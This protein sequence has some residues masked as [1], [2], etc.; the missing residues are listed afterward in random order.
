MDLAL[1]FLPES[2]VP[3]LAN[4][5][6]AFCQASHWAQ[7]GLSGLTQLGPALDSPVIVQRIIKGWNAIFKWSIFMFFARVQGLDKEDKRRAH[8]IKLI[9]SV[10]YTLC[11]RQGPLRD[12]ITSTPMSIEL[13]IKLWL[14]EDD[15][16]LG[17]QDPS[18]TALLLGRMIR[19]KEHLDRVL[20]A[21]N[22]KADAITKI[23]IARLKRVLDARPLNPTCLDA[24]LSAINALSI[25]H[26][27]PLRHAF[28]GANIIWHATSALGPISTDMATSHDPMFLDAM[29]TAF[30]IV[31]NHL[32]STDGFT[33]VSQA[34]GAGLLTYFAD[35][36]QY[37]SRLHPIDLE[38]VLLL[39]Q[40]KLPPYTVYR[41]VLEAMEASMSRINEGPKRR[42]IMSS[43]AKDA[44]LA[45]E[46]LYNVRTAYLNHSRSI[47]GRLRGCDNIKVRVPRPLLDEVC[48]NRLKVSEEGRQGRGTEVLG[49]SHY[50]LLLQGLAR[51]P[52]SR[53]LL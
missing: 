39:I 27:H 30:L 20:A 38:R 18:P 9:P 50:I 12:K 4:S 52:C 10:W 35:C 31:Y 43:P 3:G 8:A 42:K 5:V 16:A 26:L 7:I 34:V 28:L 32:D 13:A 6:T 41:S 53:S 51:H 22:G 17:A 29:S 33:W 14:E 11:S 15:T 23:A 19:T 21:V 49:M 44:W 25:M 40:R 48:L 37:F 36:S 45:F 46:K 47:D 24:Q 1:S 2:D